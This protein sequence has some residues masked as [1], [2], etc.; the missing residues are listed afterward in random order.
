MPAQKIIIDPKNQNARYF[1]DIWSFKGLFYFLAWRD[2][3][4][5]YKQT[6][7]GVMWAL[8]RPLLT[9]FALT[10]IRLVLNKNEKSLIPTPL[11]I[12]AGTLPWTFFSSAFSDAA[13]SLVANAN[14]VS[15]V[16]FPRIIV[17]ASAV[18]VCLI[19]F[20]ISF[21]IVLGIM[22]YYHLVPGV[23]IVFLPAFLLLAIITSLGCGL[24]IAALN[25][26]YRDFRY[27]IPFIV[28][29][30][31][32]VSPV[33]FSSTEIYQNASIPGWL[34][35]IYSLN[36]MVCVIDGFRWCMFGE[37][38]SIDTTKFLVSMAVSLLM[39]LIGIITFRKMEKDFADVI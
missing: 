13:N 34:K 18:I 26:K 10:L 7:I 22:F 33:M 38:V 29:F 31:M 28:Q 19:D 30:G 27:I 36:P 12:A 6:S 14:L 4:V 32:F 15:K 24:Y 5:R 39:L 17:P 1:R 3:R 21:V 37:Q 20:F 35:E 9:I 2:V 25:V 16:Y 8:L 23:Q 11:L